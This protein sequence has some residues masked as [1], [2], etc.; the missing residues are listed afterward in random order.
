MKVLTVMDVDGHMR[1]YDISTEKSAAKVWA[2]FL[3]EMIENKCFEED[4]EKEAYRIIFERDFDKAEALIQ[5]ADCTPYFDRS[6][7]GRMYIGEM[8]TEWQTGQFD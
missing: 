1:V 8:T 6:G 7:G 3:K 5:D 2:A 4:E